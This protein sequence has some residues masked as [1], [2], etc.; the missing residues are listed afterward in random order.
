[1]KSKVYRMKLT[2]YKK[3]RHEFPAEYKESVA[4]Y[5][6]RLVKWLDKLKGGQN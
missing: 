2:T 3:L 5:F 4:H 6:E 1:M